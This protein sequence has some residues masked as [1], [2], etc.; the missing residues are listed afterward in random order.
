M[1]TMLRH[2]RRTIAV[3]AVAGRSADELGW[4]SQIFSHGMNMDLHG[5]VIGQRRRRSDVAE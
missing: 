5:E 4:A 1:A 2:R 3:V